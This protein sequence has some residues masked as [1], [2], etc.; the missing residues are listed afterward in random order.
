M[1]LATLKFA[2]LALAASA[3]A[4]SFAASAED[5]AE[6]APPAGMTLAQAKAD[7]DNWRPVDPEN[8]F[9][10]DTTKG[11]VL[12]EAFPEIAPKHYEQF[13]TIIRSGDFDGT[14]FHRV[15]D[16]FMAQGGD[17]FALKGRDSGLPDLEGEFTFRRDPAAMPLEAT[18]GPED[19]AK[20]GYIKGFPIGTQASF[21]AEMSVDGM[22]ESYIPHCKGMVSTART[23]DPN[24]ANSQFFLMRGQAEH[25][26]RKYTAWGRV[27]VGEDVVMAIKHGPDARDGHVDNPDILKSAKVAADLPEG[28]RP[29][30]WVERTDGPLFLAEMADK[31]DIDV[32]SLPSVPAVVGE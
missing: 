25:L 29:E 8:L 22:V 14:S 18:I 28:E 27:V 20:F 2:S 11:R 26:D 21:F 3:M 23:D 10:F 32:C 1:N 15:I 9:I 6:A 7:P 13:S 4:L 19:T 16:D 12:I 24:S 5:A 17:I 31:D 30:V